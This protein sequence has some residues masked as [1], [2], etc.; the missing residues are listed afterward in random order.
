M[1]VLQIADYIYP[2]ISGIGVTAMDIAQALKIGV[3]DMKQ[4]IICINGFTYRISTN[5]FFVYS[6]SEKS[7]E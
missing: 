2:Q 6:Y 7:Y 3:E 4:K 5:L 1:K